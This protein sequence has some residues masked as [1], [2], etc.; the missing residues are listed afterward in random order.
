MMCIRVGLTTYPLLSYH[1]HTMIVYS[2]NLY[3]TITS[4]KGYIMQQFNV[5]HQPVLRLLLK[6]KACGKSF[7][8]NLAYIKGRAECPNCGWTADKP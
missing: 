7:P 3:Q 6:C 1:S 4:M 2:T 5:I 8:E